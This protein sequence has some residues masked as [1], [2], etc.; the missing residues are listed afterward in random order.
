MPMMDR[1]GRDPSRQRRDGPGVRSP[2]GTP[3]L[4]GLR[5]PR[6][7][8]SR[9]GRASSTHRSPGPATVTFT[10]DVDSSDATFELR[11]RPLGGTAIR[12]KTRVHRPRHADVAARGVLLVAGALRH[13]GED[14]PGG[15]LSGREPPGESRELPSPAPARRRSRERRRTRSCRG[16]TTGTR[17]KRRIRFT[18][19]ADVDARRP[20]SSRPTAAGS[21]VASLIRD[22]PSSEAWSAGSNH[23]DWDGQGEGSFAGNRPAGN[24]FVKIWADDGTARPRVVQTEEGRRSSGPTGRP[25]SRPSRARRTTTRTQSRPRPRRRLLRPRTGRVPPGPSARER[26]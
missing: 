24:Y 23:W 5:G 2:D 25:R 26:G 7:S 10:F 1:C 12:E 22:G 16:S 20:A 11:L 18:L 14:V 9:G 17:T 21:A 6:A 4:G 19:A 13:V 8:R 15:R 3:R